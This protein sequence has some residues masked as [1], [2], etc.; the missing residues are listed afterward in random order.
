MN[1]MLI[2]CIR[3]AAKNN[4][5]LYEG[6]YAFTIGPSYETKSEIK[7]II[8]LNGSAVGMSTFP[9]Y[10]KSKSLKIHPLFIS[11][12][13]N[14]GAGLTNKKINHSDVLFTCHHH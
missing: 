8:S 11:C 1:I 3:T 7:E 12:L 4:I 6:T 13:T 2:V 5:Q 9:E 14:Y 10:I